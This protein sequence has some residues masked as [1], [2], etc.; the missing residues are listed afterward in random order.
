MCRPVVTMSVRNG[1]DYCGD[2]DGDA[3]TAPPASAAALPPG[4]S[5]AGGGGPRVRIRAFDGDVAEYKEWK[6]EVE[7]TA[8]LYNVPDKQLAGLVYL[9][10]SP[11]PGKPRDLIS[12]MDVRTEICADGGLEAVWKILDKEYVREDYV[13][14][15]EAQAR[16]DRCRRAP[17]QSMDEFIREAR[18]S[19]RLL[20]R[21]DPGTTISEIAFAR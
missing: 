20:E 6:R 9:A 14:A 21:E 11:G 4:S 10:L 16:Y 17:G 3:A 1:V 15:D 12:H 5:G 13:K 2:D 19:K 7:T 18:L 8:F